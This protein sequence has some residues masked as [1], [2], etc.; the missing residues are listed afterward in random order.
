MRLRA[1]CN[2]VGSSRAAPARHHRAIQMAWMRLR[3]RSAVAHPRPSPPAC[4]PSRLGFWPELHSTCMR[5]AHHYRHMCRDLRGL[6]ETDVVT[7]RTNQRSGRSAHYSC[8][9]TSHRYSALHSRWR[10]YARLIDSAQCDDWP[11]CMYVLGGSAS[12]TQSAGFLSSG[13]SILAGGFTAGEKSSR[14]LPLDTDA[15]RG[16]ARH[17]TQ[18]QPTRTVGF[19]MLTASQHHEGT[20]AI[21]LTALVET[22]HRLQH[23][24]HQQGMPRSAF[25]VRCCKGPESW[26]ALILGRSVSRTSCPA[27]QRACT[28][29]K[30]CR[31]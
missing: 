29:A 30:A 26:D 24:P 20:I 13:S 28:G 5:Q 16:A 21:R 27:L 31:P 12:S 23:A 1:C 17:I 9:G 7:Y 25:Q 15:E 2:A 22:A 19:C 18:A 14:R 8:A 3:P 11:A 10:S 6:W 4:S